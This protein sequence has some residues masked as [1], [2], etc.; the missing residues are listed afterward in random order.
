MENTILLSP[1]Q[2]FDQTINQIWDCDNGR[3]FFLESQDIVWTKKEN[4]S[5]PCHAASS[6]RHWELFL[7][8]YVIIRGK[9]GVWLLEVLLDIF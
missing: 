8:P 5:F 7:T 1:L 4:A 6:Y 3:N 9:A 2:S